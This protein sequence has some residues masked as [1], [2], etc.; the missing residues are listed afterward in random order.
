MKRILLSLILSIM[1]LTAFSK[2]QVSA[3]LDR[4][5]I[6]IGEQ[7]QLD[8]RIEYTAGNHQI[9]FPALQD[10]ISKFIEVVEFGP[11]DTTFD[12]DD[13]SQMILEQKIIVTS[14][15]SGYHVIPP[16]KFIFNSDT[17]LTKPMMLS[18][19]DVA[20]QA[21]Q[22]IKDIKNILEVPFSLTDWLLANK[23]PLGI[24][25][26]LLLLLI[27]LYLAYR[28]YLKNKAI[29]KE[30]EVPKEAADVL[31]MKKL[32]ELKQKKLWQAGEVKAYY[33]ELSFIIREY[34][35]NRYRI[36][37]LEQSTHEIITSIKTL[38]L[39]DKENITNLSNF[40]ELADIAKFAKGTPLASENEESLK[41]AYR[42]VE[43]TRFVEEAKEEEEIKTEAAHA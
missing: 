34:L 35:E 40:L 43:Q 3:S 27:A 9:L 1:M 15:D 18:V 21:E 11:I 17:L 38:E 2:N 13:V 37:A 41:F 39:I 10:T 42:F 29:V 33:S 32:Q 24:G 5:E 25:L 22:D 30:V 16:F 36:L 14:W 12:E 20:I 7:V 26:G 6:K 19:S 8:L 23:K 31:A 4:Q 28:R